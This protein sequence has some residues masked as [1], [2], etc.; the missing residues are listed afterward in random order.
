MNKT[1][2]FLGM[3]L[4]FN[5]LSCVSLHLNNI[6]QGI[7]HYS[8]GE[9]KEA[10]TVLESAK[11]TNPKIHFYLAGAYAEVKEYKKSYSHYQELIKNNPEFL[12]KHSRLF[13]FK[14]IN[15]VINSPDYS[16]E[17]VKI[18]YEEKKLKEANA[19]CQK[20][21]EKNPDYIN[22]LVFIGNIYSAE[23]KNKEALTM[24]EKVILQNPEVNEEIG[25]QYLESLKKVLLKEPQVTIS[26][27]SLNSIAKFNPNLSEEI[28]TLTSSVIKKQ[29]LLAEKLIKKGEFDKDEA[30]LRKIVD[31]PNAVKIKYFEEAIYQ[32][33]VSDCLAKGFSQVMPKIKKIKAGYQYE[34]K[35]N[36]L[37]AFFIIP[38]RKIKS[39]MLTGWSP[40]MIDMK[41]NYNS[42]ANYWSTGRTYAGRTYLGNG[43]Y[44]DNYYDNYE[45]D[46]QIE[47]DMSS[48]IKQGINTFSVSDGPQGTSYVA[49]YSADKFT[50]ELKITLGNKNK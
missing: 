26:L 28:K 4:I 22:A 47:K 12:K 32:L 33:E 44:Q 48:F 34:Y 23:G 11:K 9:Y 10:I 21:L 13:L 7:R 2:S 17:I 20:I 31:N 16:I 8:A 5:L 40:K 43:Y 50:L 29:V 14:R 15:S 49:G 45:G 19:L 37:K 41:L 18:Y 36:D 24:F 25:K 30:I 1:L 38:K 42:F 3:F 27:K 35:L 39:V 46:R 6:R